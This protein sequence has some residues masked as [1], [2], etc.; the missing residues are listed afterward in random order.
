MKKTLIFVLPFVDMVSNHVRATC[1]SG[2]QSPKWEFVY[3]K[4]TYPRIL[5]FF[6]SR[7]FY[8]F[9][10]YLISTLRVS[11]AKK[12]VIYFT[13]PQN[14]LILW[15]L[16]NVFRKNIVIDIHDGIHSDE[17]LGYRKSAALIKNSDYIIFESI[18]N[19]N[20]WR[21]KI[22]TPFSIIE[23]T[24]QHEC[25]YED[26]NKR[27]KN[28]IW[29]GSIHTA[30]YLVNF[31]TYFKIFDDSGYSIRLLGCT[32]Y[33][34]QLL[35]KANIRHSYLES[36][37]SATLSKELRR[38]K[39]SFVPMLDTELFRYRGNLKAKIS[40]AYGCLT[41]A[42]NIDMHKRLINH[43]KTGYLF[44]NLEEFEDIILALDNNQKNSDIAFQGNKY[45]L[46][47]FTRQRHAL[48]L[49][50][51]MSDMFFKV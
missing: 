20:Y 44:N 26:F 1:L 15:L 35:A 30:K 31:I 18:E 46:E 22:N 39:I 32:E 3:I 27:K 43:N 2:Y 16:K 6:P 4:G 47:N 34:S 41:I 29:V 42:S 36:Y 51:S 13:S 19:A 14:P 21:N 24:P 49:T 5:N 45:V 25:L 28:V 9:I 12:T 33:V 10:F 40:M 48:K 8:R 11:Y 23:D 50:S 17:L 38:S 37:D 7:F